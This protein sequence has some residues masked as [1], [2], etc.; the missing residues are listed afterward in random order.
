[1]PAAI[2]GVQM[3]ACSTNH[4][5]L[6]STMPPFEAHLHR[7]WPQIQANTVST[8]MGDTPQVHKP[9]HSDKLL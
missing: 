1:M 2:L 4:I 5:E 9:K 6:R 3:H 8:Y 7:P